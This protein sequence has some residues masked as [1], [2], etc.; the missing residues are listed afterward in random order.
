MTERRGR[1][2]ATVA[3]TAALAA[4]AAGCSSTGESPTPGNTANSADAT[5]SASAPSPGSTGAQVAG[6]TDAQAAQLCSDIE[7]QLQNWRTYTP[8]LGKGGLNTVVI[9][10]ATANGMDLL[11]LAG[12]RGQIDAI[13]VAQ[14]PQVRDG[15]LYA[16]EIPNLASGLVGF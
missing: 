4:L 12:D 9:S 5:S 8:T 13:T 10:W 2:A 16:L 11:K 3:V 7:A 14:C 1:L 15:A 6:V